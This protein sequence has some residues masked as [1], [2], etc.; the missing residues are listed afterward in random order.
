VSIHFPLSLEGA[1]TERAGV[2]GFQAPVFAPQH[3][4]GKPKL[5]GEKY[6][7]LKEKTNNG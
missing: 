1:G 7:T 6:L 4:E 3:V 5:G 2:F